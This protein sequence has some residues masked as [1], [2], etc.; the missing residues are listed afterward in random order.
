MWKTLTNYKTCKHWQSF[1]IN[2]DVAFYMLS[3]SPFS[4]LLLSVAPSSIFPV[5]LH[6]ASG[7]KYAFCSMQVPTTGFPLGCTET[8]QPLSPPHKTCFQFAIQCYLSRDIW[9]LTE[10]QGLNS[11]E[12]FSRNYSHQ[13]QG[14]VFV[15]RAH[16]WAF[17]LLCL[18]VRLRWLWRPS[19]LFVIKRESQVQDTN[20]SRYI[21]EI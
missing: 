1:F 9:T 16:S 21:T 19:F 14:K 5:S 8:H 11:K 12:W 4:W 20:K 6:R 7:T 15:V 10:D 18:H 17:H 13:W 2:Y 3:L